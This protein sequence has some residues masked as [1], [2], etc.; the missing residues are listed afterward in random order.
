[1]WSFLVLAAMLSAKL[2]QV[3]ILY[4]R[5]HPWTIAI[6]TPR[7]LGN[8]STM[9]GNSTK[10]AATE[11]YREET[12]DK[13]KK[14]GEETKA[15][16]KTD[17]IASE[18][19]ALGLLYPPGIL[20]GYG[21]QVIRFISLVEY[22]LRQDIPNLF[23]PS[24]WWTT[25][26]PTPTQSDD[27]SHPPLYPYPI[28]MDQVFDVQ[29]WNQIASQPQSPLPYLVNHHPDVPSLCWKT[30]KSYNNTPNEHESKDIGDK[31][32]IVTI[33]HLSTKTPKAVSSV[34][35]W[36]LESILSRHGYIPP[37]LNQTVQMMTNTYAN[38]RRRD[39]L[40]NV[41]HC[42]TSLLFYG[43]GT[44]GGRLWNDAMVR[45]NKKNSSERTLE[46]Q[47]RMALQPAP[48]WRHVAEKCLESR[49]ASSFSQQ[50]DVAGTPAAAAAHD[51]NYVAL[52]ARIELEMMGHNCGRNMETS[53]QRILDQVRHLLNNSHEKHGLLDTPPLG[54]LLVVSRGGIVGKGFPAGLASRFKK[55][56]TNNA[57]TLA[58]YVDDHGHP[59][60]E[61][62]HFSPNH[63]HNNNNSINNNG[64]NRTT[65]AIPI[66]ECGS[67]ALQEYYERRQKNPTTPNESHEDENQDDPI[68]NHGSLIESMTNF[69]S[70]V[71]A[72]IFV[73][74][75]GSSYSTDVWT[76]RFLKGK[77]DAN[78]HYT[79][80]GVI[81]PIGNGGLPDPHVTCK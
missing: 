24:L 66:F 60:T 58:R 71:N 2:I 65:V 25:Q 70:A 14:K 42:N 74:V 39:F 77:G 27:S 59:T 61:R 73:G 28:P 75:K 37:L 68:Q 23:L 17:W 9:T 34:A 21:N 44:A 43:G 15:E 22:A 48:R 29:L 51:Y 11:A 41:A 50:Q 6:T 7:T 1:M 79:K 38:P 35:V 63:N 19:K 53:L 3:N 31:T 57:E 10:S 36:P 46:F 67:F 76:T 12:R 4:M 26:V 80:A 5:A 8:S 81:E 78:Y 62:L 52:H 18:E 47:V 20:G 32:A 72:R 54:L 56:A 64:S 45:H 69:Y 30:L 33:R 49:M 40:S 13:R 16:N 55:E